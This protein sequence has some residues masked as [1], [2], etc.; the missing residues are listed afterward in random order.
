MKK[1]IILASMAGLICFG[2]CKNP[3]TLKEKQEAVKNGNITDSYVYEAKEVGWTTQLPKDWSVL[4]SQE[5]DQLNQKGKELIKKNINMDVDM[6]GLKQLVSLK[7]N[8]FNQFISTI[9]RY[10]VAENGSYIEK[11]D[12]VADLMAQTYKSKQMKFIYSQDSATISGLNFYIIDFTI[13]KPNSSDVLMRQ[14]MYSRLMHGYDFSMTMMYNNPADSTTLQQIIS[15]SQF[16]YK[17]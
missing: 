16:S 1:L 4:T 15:N 12:Q 7:K 5:T 8:P 3:Q 2:S 10:D 9:E 6:S 17:D 14:K 13:Y 11:N